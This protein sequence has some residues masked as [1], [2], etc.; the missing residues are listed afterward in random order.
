M[1]KLCFK[2]LFNK[3]KKKTLIY[4]N[5]VFW[6]TIFDYYVHH[7]CGDFLFRYKKCLL[8]MVWAIYLDL[9]SNYI[10]TK[11]IIKCS[12][13]AFLNFKC[14]CIQYQIHFMF[15]NSDEIQFYFIYHNLDN[16]N[17]CARL[18]HL[19]YKLHF[20][21]L[22]PLRSIIIQLYIKTHN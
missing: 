14:Q 10:P 22:M 9:K 11:I 19:Q 21:C 17:V 3:K 1:K 8:Q 16:Y 7:L 2:F 15:I 18:A 13:N 6:M 5:V 20:F 12:C 4:R